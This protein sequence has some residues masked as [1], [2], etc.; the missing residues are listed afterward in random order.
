MK[1]NYH[2][3]SFYEVPFWAMFKS[4]FFFKSQTTTRGLVCNWILGLQC[5]WLST[6]GVFSFNIKNPMFYILS[7][8]ESVWLGFES[9]KVG[10][11]LLSCWCELFKIL[12]SPVWRVIILTQLTQMLKFLLHCIVNVRDLLCFKFQL[13]TNP[14]DQFS[15]VIPNGISYWCQ[16][17]IFVGSPVRDVISPNP[18]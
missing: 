5:S 1:I 3:K 14:F 6:L 12:G 9:L 7:H 15:N 13:M 16:I 10:H 11:L 17:C 2:S 18:R 4:T 8:F